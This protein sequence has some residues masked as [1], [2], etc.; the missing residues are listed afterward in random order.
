MTRLNTQPQ[1]QGEAA[2]AVFDDD[3]GVADAYLERAGCD[4]RYGLSL[5]I[6]DLQIVGFPC[7]D[8]R[9]TWDRHIGRRPAVFAAL[10]TTDTAR[11]ASSIWG[12]YTGV[13]TR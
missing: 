1:D 13:L 2:L 3:P 10:V 7:R 5:V 6:I 8:P 12:A 4:H 9:L 11:R